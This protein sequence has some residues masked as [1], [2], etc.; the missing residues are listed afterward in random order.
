MVALILRSPLLGRAIFVASIIY[1]VLQLGVF[2][3]R[4]WARQDRERDVVNYHIAAR[5]V[6]EHRP[7]YQIPTA[8]GPDQTLFVYIYAPPYAAL[9]APLGRLPFPTFARLWSVLLLLGFWG[10][11]WCLACLYRAGARQTLRQWLCAALA[12]GLCYGS[13]RALALGEV[14]PML[15]LLFGL[16]LVAMPSRAQGSSTAWIVGAAW[17]AAAMTKLFFAW[18]LLA[19]LCLLGPSARRQVM[20]GGAAVVLPALLIGYARCG[21][22][23]FASWLREVL[24]ALG[25]GTFNGDNFS[26]SMAALRLARAVGWEYSGG[27]LPEAARLWLSAAT[28]GGP[29]LMFWFSRRHSPTVRCAWVGAAAALC[30]PTCWSSYLPILL[31]P[32]ALWLGAQPDASV[33]TPQELSIEPRT[34]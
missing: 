17:A 5:A 4:N 1:C 19:A 14:D 20:A 3:P 6:L 34:G 21:G 28:A 31:A 23:A 9:I 32:G 15:W 24:P 11:A 2:V 25:Q 18:P 27:P 29:M 10:Y 13:W 16:G 8:F 12:V 26:L 7:L 22:E 30:A 33:P